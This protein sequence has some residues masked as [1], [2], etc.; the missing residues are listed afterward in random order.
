MRPQT[1]AL[2]GPAPRGSSG[3]LPHAKSQERPE[4]RQGTYC[5]S[6]G[7]LVLCFI[8]LDATKPLLVTWATA[9][10]APSERFILG[11]FVLVQT[12]LSL[13]VGLGLAMAPTLALAPL[14]LRLHPEWRVRVYRCVEPRE[15][16]KRLPVSGCLCFS[17]LLLV[18][19]LGRLDAGTVRVFGQASIPLV[20]VSSALFFSKRY[21]LQQWASLAAISI[22]LITFYYVKAEVQKKNCQILERREPSQRLEVVGVLLILCSIA[23]NCLGALLVEKFLKGN[24]SRLHVQKAQLLLGEVI[25]NTGLIVVVPF[26][27]TDPELRAANSPWVRGFFAGWDG[28]VLLCAIVWIPAGWTATMLVKRCSN[29]L[30]TVAQSTSSVLTYA[31]SVLPLSSGP[32]FWSYLVTLLG[33]PLTPEPLSSPVILLA[34]TV[35]LAA[36]SFGTDSGAAALASGRKGGGEHGGERPPRGSRAL[37]A[38]PEAGGSAGRRRWEPRPGAPEDTSVAGWKVDNA[39]GQLLHRRSEQASLAAQR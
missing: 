27:Y 16:L 39:Y 28:R 9:Q 3:P 36:I 30:K 31:F 32:R 24:K 12:T 22:A 38:S 2:A 1:V 18:M 34:V 21:T 35:M 11:T 29:L 26:C 19:A 13:L 37:E 25:V 8:L 23:F 5:Q 7:C 33:P 17:K 15:V 4:E 14:R 20:G 10:K 6:I